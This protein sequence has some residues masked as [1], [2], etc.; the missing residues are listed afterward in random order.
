MN[1]GEV[2]Y[3]ITDRAV[4]YKLRAKFHIYIGDAG[5]REEGAAFMFVNSDNY[6]G[7]DY[8]LYSKDYPFLI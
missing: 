6:N 1:V 4:G 3:W 5:W 2:Y 7:A 8:P